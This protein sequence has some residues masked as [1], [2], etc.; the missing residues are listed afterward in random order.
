MSKSVGFTE[1]T[2]QINNMALNK[3]DVFCFLAEHQLCCAFSIWSSCD[4]EAKPQC[5]GVWL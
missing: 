4:G 2:Q 3:F 5:S 1:V